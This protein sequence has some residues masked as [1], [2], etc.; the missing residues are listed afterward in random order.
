MLDV[1]HGK[2]KDFEKNFDIARKIIASMQRIRVTRTPAILEIANRY[3]LLV[4]W[5]KLEDHTVGFRQS[6][7]V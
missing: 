3:V 5:E 1:I 4:R 7:G 2:E 6:A